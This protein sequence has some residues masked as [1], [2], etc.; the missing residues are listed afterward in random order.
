MPSPGLLWYDSNTSIVLLNADLHFSQA[1]K[2][3]QLQLCVYD[4]DD[5]DDAGGGDDDEFYAFGGGEGP[6][7]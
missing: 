6:E 5:A 2:E 3:G 4:F 7:Y 1:K